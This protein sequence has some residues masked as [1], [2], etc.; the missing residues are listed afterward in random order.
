MSTITAASIVVAKFDKTSGG[1]GRPTF[2]TD[3]GGN[4]L[5]QYDSKAVSEAK[6]SGRGGSSRSWNWV[7]AA[8]R[9]SARALPLLPSM[10]AHANQRLR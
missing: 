10:H 7:S 4:S 1:F 5:L 2:T 6:S 9:C 8:T 3:G